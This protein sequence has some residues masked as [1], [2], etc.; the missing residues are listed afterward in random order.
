M[1]RYDMKRV[2]RPEISV[3]MGVYNQH[4]IEQLNQAVD[5]ILGQTY[6]DFEFIIYDDGSDEEPAAYVKQLEERDERI[7]VIRCEHNRGLA[8]SLNEC[9]GV[10]RGRYLARMD[11]DDISLPDRLETEYGFLEQ[12]KEY[13]WV[14]CNAKVFDGDRIWGTYVMAEEPNQ[15]NFLPFSP[16]I[17][18]TVMFRRELF[19]AG[20]GYNIQEETLRCEDYELFMRLYIQGYRGYNIQKEMFLYREGIGAYRRR[21]W[22]SRMNEA[23]IRR[24][25]FPKMDLPV[26]K[27]IMYILRPVITAFIPYPLVALYKKN[28]LRKLNR[29]HESEEIMDV[30]IY[31]KEYAR[32]I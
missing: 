24:V 9:I 28:R 19:E 8:F 20:N 30:H 15:Y 12:H 6:G 32:T 1:G 21:T 27:Q 11:A 16:Y 4:D 31:F 25:N 17:H 23:R 29:K 13:A 10:A 22:I 7:R 14:G 5:S 18:P 26:N 2:E 3:I